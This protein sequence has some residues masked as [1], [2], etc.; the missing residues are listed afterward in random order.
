MVTILFLL[1]TVS[2]GGW[3]GDNDFDCIGGGDNR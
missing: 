3:D 1:M 2:V